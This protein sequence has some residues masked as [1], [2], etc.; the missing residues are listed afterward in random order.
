MKV[1]L[2]GGAGFIGS[3]LTE[4]LLKKGHDLTV[5]DSL[6]ATLYPPEWKRK[7]LVEA[8]KES[9]FRFFEGG[10]CSHGSMKAVFEAVQPE[11]VIHLAALPGI[12]QSILNPDRYETVNVGGTL[13]MLQ[14][15]RDH[16]VKKFIFASS[17]SVYGTAPRV[18]VRERDTTLRPLSPYAATKVA[19]EAHCY[20]F[21][22]LYGIST[23]VLRFFTVYG[24]RQRPDMAMHQFVRA[25]EKGEEIT[26]YGDVQSSRDFTHVSDVVE[27]ILASMDYDPGPTTPFRVFNLGSGK[28]V[29]LNDLI[30]LL[31]KAM[32]G[33]QAEIKYQEAR[34]GDVPHTWADIQ[35]AE[36]VLKWKPTMPLELGIEQYVEWFRAHPDRWE[37]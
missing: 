29:T 31:W 19:A 6:D 33:K 27:G 18:P 14:Q 22:H 28:P 32:P 24:P 37:I 12:Q 20:T 23:T 17:S 1:L 7:N 26:I 2:T 5:V 34:I 9:G 13:T 15:C 21:A 4:G 35:R 30:G 11:I 36:L 16:G 25:I 10:V 3:H 8:R